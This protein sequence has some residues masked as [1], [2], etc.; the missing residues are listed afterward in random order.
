MGVIRANLGASEMYSLPLGICHGRGLRMKLS[1][2]RSSN[3][4]ESKGGCS[5]GEVTG[6]KPV[7]RGSSDH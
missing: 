1:G 3:E 7:V 4:Q 2:I 6:M 5:G